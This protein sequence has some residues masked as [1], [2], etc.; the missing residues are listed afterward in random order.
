M[1]IKRRHLDWLILFK[2]LNAHFP[3]GCW[4][5]CDIQ[6]V[7]VSVREGPI[8]VPHGKIVYV[9]GHHWL[10]VESEWSP[11]VGTVA[12]TLERHVQD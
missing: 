7:Y 3:P 11:H 12:I 4:G 1:N 2:C 6:R 8:Y 9:K 5:F 10:I